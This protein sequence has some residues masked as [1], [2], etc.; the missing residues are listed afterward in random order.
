LPRNHD[1]QQASEAALREAVLVLAM[2]LAGRLEPGKPWLSRLV[3][4]LPGGRILNVQLFP[5]AKEPHRQ[6]LE[7][8]RRAVLSKNFAFV[9]NSLRL[10]D[11]DI[12]ECFDRADLCAVL[13][14]RLADGL[15]AWARV[16]LADYEEPRDFET[17]LREGWP[18]GGRQPVKLAQVYCLFFRE[19]LKRRPPVFRIL[20]TDTLNE[21]RARL[22]AQGAQ[23]SAELKALR[24]KLD[25]LNPTQLPL[26]FAALE[27]WLEPQ[28]GQIKDL[29]GEA[30]GQL[31]AVARS[32]GELAEKQGEIL[33]ALTALRSE[34]ARDGPAAAAASGQLRELAD[35]VTRVE[36]KVDYLIGGLS[37]ERFQSPKPPTHDLELLWANQRAVDLVGRDT[38]LNSLWQWLTAGENIAARLLVGRAGT[39]KTRLAYELLL[40]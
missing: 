22:A 35:Y 2:E 31:D 23:V 13:G 7:A 24:E 6:W 15:L 29:L 19:H 33:V 1:L 20:V 5:R 25:A 12:R 32:Q 28:L 3:E 11:N 21:L 14:P 40:Q 10:S 16:E 18:A 27:R 9:H 38:D 39:G 37:V 34:V 8:L 36:R 17:L 30:K 26:D 4:N